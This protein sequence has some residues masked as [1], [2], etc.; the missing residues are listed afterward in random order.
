VIVND[1]SGLLFAP[2]DVDGLAQQLESLS[3]SADMRR[4]LGFS[5]RQR[6]VS[7]FSLQRMIADYRHLYLGLAAKRGICAGE[8]V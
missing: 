8:R 4:N 3:H 1:G 2:G 6:A 7:L 5:A